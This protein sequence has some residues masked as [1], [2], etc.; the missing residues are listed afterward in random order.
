M[1]TAM[2][3]GIKTLTFVYVPREDR[4]MT[5]INAGLAD[6]WS[7]WLTRRLSL[8]VL[9]RAAVYLNSTSQ[10]AQRAPAEL[11]GEMT[12]FEREAGIAKTAGSMSVTPPD[13]LKQS[14][15]GAELADRLVIAQQGEAFRLELRGQSEEGAAGLFK[16][17]ELQRTLQM[18]QIEVGKA[19]WIV[20]VAQPQPSRAPAA[21]DTKPFR[22]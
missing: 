12:A 8:A 10:L 6:A 14:E 2:L 9:D 21:T 13:V 15:T 11:R 17:A 1:M 19:G 16:R 3:R 7:C 22:H 4:I 5:A 18:L 20:A